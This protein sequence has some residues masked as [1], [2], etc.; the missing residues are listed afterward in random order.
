M[1]AVQGY[2]APGATEEEKEQMT[3][4]VYTCDHCGGTF[5]S[6]RS[7]DEVNQEAKDLYGVNEASTDPSMAEVCDDCFREFVMWA[8]QNGI[9]E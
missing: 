1:K 2:A 6:E 9:I 8:K 4:H 3:S 7:Q 5:T